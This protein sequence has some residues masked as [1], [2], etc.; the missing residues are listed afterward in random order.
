[1]YDFLV[2]TG[3]KVLK[4]VPILNNLKIVKVMHVLTTSFQEK[5]QAAEKL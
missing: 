2:V 1:M 3:L 5:H 4:P